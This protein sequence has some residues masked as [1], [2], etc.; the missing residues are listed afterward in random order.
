MRR[1]L[2]L[3]VLS[4]FPLLATAQQSIFQPGY[5]VRR[6][7]PTDTVRGYVD[8]LRATRILGQVRFRATPDATVETL[9]AAQLSAAGTTDGRQ[10]FRAR[11]ITGDSLRILEVISSGPLS[12]YTGYTPL[13]AVDFMLEQAGS[14]VLPLARNQFEPMLQNVVAQCPGLVVADRGKQ[15][16]LYARTPL[17]KM[18]NQYNDCQPTTVPN[19][20]YPGA[21]NPVTLGIRAGLQRSQLW[22]LDNNHDFGY[23]RPS[24]NMNLTAALQ[25]VLPIGG[26]FRAVVEGIY[27]KAHSYVV[28]RDRP[29]AAV[30]YFVRSADL[31]AEL[32]QIPLML[33]WQVGRN[34]RRLHPYLEGG[35]GISYLLNSRAWYQAI[36]EASYDKPSAYDLGMDKWHILVRGGGGI[37][38]RTSIGLLDLGFHVQSMNIESPTER[39]QYKLQQSDLSL[40]YSRFL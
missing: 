31:K 38:Y 21:R 2:Y 25:L 5:I 26:G 18:V 15:R 16:L 8:V 3:G 7:A 6:T 33:R 9:R 24:S 30:N 14:N 37:T 40:T 11:L 29:T 27:T 20:Y 34:E 17:A 10:A 36:P 23:R 22:Y 32:L 39:T 12:L 35:G 28:V 4:L 13:P 1:F 19:R